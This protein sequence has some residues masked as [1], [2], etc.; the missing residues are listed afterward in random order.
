MKKVEDLGPKVTVD[1]NRHVAQALTRIPV[2]Q[3]EQARAK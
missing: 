1:E 3:V 2:A